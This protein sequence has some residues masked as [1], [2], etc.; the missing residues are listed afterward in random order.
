MPRE[1]GNEA[2]ATTETLL[3]MHPARKWMALK[4]DVENHVI[5][6]ERPHVTMFQL[7][8]PFFGAGVRDL[9]AEEARDGSTAHLLE[10]GTW[11]ISRLSSPRW[12]LEYQWSCCNRSSK[13]W[14]QPR[15]GVV[16]CLL[17]ADYQV[18]PD[19]L[20]KNPRWRSGVF[21]L[22]PRSFH[23]KNE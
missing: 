20:Q 21:V 14:K 10:I 1:K 9:R 11:P 18:P 12:V 16:I 13:A 3:S 22:S 23:R 17:L 4:C 15:I 5:C 8:E 7:P 6:H 19:D 2:E